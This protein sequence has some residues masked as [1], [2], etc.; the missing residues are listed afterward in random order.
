[1]VEILSITLGPGQSVGEVATLRGLLLDVF[2][3]LIINKQN[4]ALHATK[5][6]FV[7]PKNTSF[8]GRK[9]V[10]TNEP[11]CICALQFAPYKVSL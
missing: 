5:Y 3:R 4:T 8:F 10:S 1:M 9:H 2:A 11:I 7:V 6:I